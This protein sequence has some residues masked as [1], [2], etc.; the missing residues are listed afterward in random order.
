M[1]IRQDLQAAPASVREYLR[2]YGVASELV[3]W[4]AL[5][6]PKDP[7]EALWVVT[8]NRAAQTFSVASFPVVVSHWDHQVSGS[9]HSPAEMMSQLEDGLWGASDALRTSVRDFIESLPA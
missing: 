5:D 6:K 1:T 2:Q 3:A 8:F 4:W 9:S 7:H